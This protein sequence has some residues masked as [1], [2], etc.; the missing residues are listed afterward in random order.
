MRMI[1]KGVLEKRGQQLR[2]IRYTV[3]VPGAW[4][5]VLH[6]EVSERLIGEA[7]RLDMLLIKSE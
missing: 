4:N 7:R 6:G 3:F 5:N 2:M 1:L